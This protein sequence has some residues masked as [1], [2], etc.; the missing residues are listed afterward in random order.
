[1]KRPE[2][3]LAVVHDLKSPLLAIE[4]LSELLLE[5]QDEVSEDLRRDLELIHESAEEASDYLEK[6]TS[7]SALA[8]G[9][10]SDAS[11]ERVDVREVVREVVDGLRPNAE[12]KNQPLQYA[13]EGQ[14]NSGYQVRGIPFQLREAVNN[15]VS[16]ALKFSPP[17][18]PVD[19]RVSREDGAVCVS[20][21]DEG[22]GVREENQEQLFEPF[23]TGDPDPTGEEASTG[24][25]L[26]IVK[27][28]VQQHDGHV[29]ITSAKGEGS[30]FKLVLPSVASA[31]A[32]EESEQEH[33]T[34]G[35]T[36][37][38]DAKARV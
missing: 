26:Y 34:S 35:R 21:S 3:I 8:V 15:L 17:G 18:K 5:K 36:A 11:P 29:R 10:S 4:H 28:I 24:I 32:F 12:C 13:V 14:G 23:Q 22:P 2:S 19:V 16:N 9:D 20:V 7:S 27:Q 25:G 33:A 37:R 31:S 1:M 38:P 6:L 30:T